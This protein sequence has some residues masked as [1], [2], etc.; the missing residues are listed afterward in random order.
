MPLHL[1]IEL[2]KYALSK[3]LLTRSIMQ[4]ISSTTAT[5]I[6]ISSFII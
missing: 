1:Y 4:P 5:S 2:V 3:E 6:L